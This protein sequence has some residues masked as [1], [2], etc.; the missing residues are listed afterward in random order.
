MSSPSHG[1][2]HNA[3]ATANNWDMRQQ[4]EMWGNFNRLAKW[5]IILSV[6]VLVGMAIFLTG[7]ATPQ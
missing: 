3:P 2:S 7:N 6:I 4:D 5:V 1:S